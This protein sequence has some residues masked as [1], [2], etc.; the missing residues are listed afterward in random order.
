M[1]CTMGL[2]AV[3]MVFC[4]RCYP[5]PVVPSKSKMSSLPSLL[6]TILPT[7]EVQGNWSTVCRGPDA[8][9][10]ECRFYSPHL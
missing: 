6:A 2:L 10:P 9:R 5:A 4:I 1:V 7:A 3:F 8:T